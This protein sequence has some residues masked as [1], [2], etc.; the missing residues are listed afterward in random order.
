MGLFVN[1]GDTLTITIISIM[2]R[3]TRIIVRTVV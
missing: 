2:I 1:A 3:I